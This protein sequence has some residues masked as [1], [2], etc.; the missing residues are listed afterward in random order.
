[1]KPMRQLA[2]LQPPLPAAT[3]T[4]GLDCSAATSARLDSSASFLLPPFPAAVDHSQPLTA[5][6]SRL[7]AA[8]TRLPAA[9]FAFRL[10]RAPSLVYFFYARTAALLFASNPHTS[11]PLRYDTAHTRMRAQQSGR[12]VRAPVHAHAAASS[13]RSLLSLSARLPACRSVCP[14][15]TSQVFVPNPIT[16][17]KAFAAF[18]RAWH[19][20]D[21]EKNEQKEIKMDAL[22]NSSRVDYI[23]S[24]EYCAARV[25][26]LTKL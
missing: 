14:S 6:H 7:H 25:S 22:I 4:A 13:L 19:N 26:A 2:R 18:E 8:H 10:G 11:I 1:M 21:E 9:F 3:S 24:L 5:Y 12:G 16:D 23:R 20:C 15:Q 17:H